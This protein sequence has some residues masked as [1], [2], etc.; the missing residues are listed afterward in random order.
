MPVATPKP[1]SFAQELKAFV[2]N[3]RATPYAE[4][5]PAATEAGWETLVTELE[6]T[7]QP[8]GTTIVRFAVAVGCEG[9]FEHFDNVT[10]RT[11]QGPG[12]VSIAARLA[13][14]QSL[15]YLFFGRLPEASVQQ[16]VVNVEA[17][18]G[19][20]KL[21][22]EDPL[23]PDDQQEYVPDSAPI[24][25]R[26]AAAEAQL[27]NLVDHLEP[28][29]VPVFI[30]L[31][32]IPAHFTNRQIVDGFIDAVDHAAVR[33]SAKE[34]LLAL[35]SKN[36]SAID[37]IA[38]TAV[39]TDEDRKKFAGVMDKHLARIEANS[40]VREVRIPGGKGSAEAATPRRRRAA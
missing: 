36:P 38:D 19:D 30:D 28:D 3:H 32:D 29:G 6:A 9:K 33:F 26:A 12:P 23:P 1:V 15:I 16:K 22:G 2:E 17:S 10:V 34:Q 37:F 39:T 27:P 25:R 21:P 40:V 4:L 13:L 18:E 24:S 5:L 14:P 35:Y 31:D 20:I 7:G 8:D 11:G